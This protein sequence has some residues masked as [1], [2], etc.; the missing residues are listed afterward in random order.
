MSDARFYFDEDGKKPIAS[1]AGKLS[2]IVF[3]ADLGTVADKTARVVEMTGWLAEALGEKIG[4]ATAEAARRAAALCKADLVTGMV[5]E[6][7]GLQGIMGRVYALRSGEGETVARAIEEHYLPRNAG[8]RLPETDA[9]GAGRRRGQ[10][11]HDR[12]LFL[13]RPC[14]DGVRGPVRSA[15]AGGTGL[16]RF[17]SPGTGTFAPRACEAGVGILVRSVR[18]ESP[19]LVSS[20]VSFLAGRLASLLEQD[21]HR[22]DTVEA[23]G[24]AGMDHPVDFALR[25]TALSV[26]REGRISVSLRGDEEGWEHPPE[27]SRLGLLDR[28][29]LT[30]DAGEGPLRRVP[31]MKGT[32]GLHIDRRE[33]RKR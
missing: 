3:Q 8:D 6:F 4:P 17:S 15:A 22:P 27:K 29:R 12:R 26:V 10:A 20:L 31:R 25:V 21:G 24:A 14:P 2:G 13:G 7:P 19:A 11:G 23:V 5:G 18:A 32:I 33:Y 28:A 16:S 30:L 9:G 1:Y